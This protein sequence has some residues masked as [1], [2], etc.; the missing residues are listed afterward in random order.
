MGSGILSAA[1]H[2]AV[3]NPDRILLSSRQS[4]AHAKRDGYCHGFSHA[5]SYANDDAKRNA[6]CHSYTQTVSYTATAPD[7]AAATVREEPAAIK[8]S[9]NYA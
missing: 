9:D 7:A 5:H 2:D 1:R 8:S 4:H 6:Q 3:A